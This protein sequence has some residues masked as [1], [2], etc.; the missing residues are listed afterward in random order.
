LQ[1]LK[2]FRETGGGALV[3]TQP[4]MAGRI[5]EWLL[6]ASQDS[7]IH[8]IASTGFHKVCYYFGDSYIFYR[9]EQEIAELYISEIEQGMLT[10]RKGGLK[11]TN[12]RAG[13]LKVVVE[14]GGIFCKKIYE[15]L[16][17]AVA[18]AQLKTG[19]PVMCHA[20]QGCDAEEVVRFYTDAGVPARSIW[21]AH[22]DRKIHDIE[23][24]KAVASSGVYLEYDTIFRPNY[25][26][27]TYECKL[28]RDMISAGYENKLLL[29]LDSNRERLE[30]Y[31]GKV[32]LSCLQEVFMPFLKSSGV[33]AGEIQKLMYD[34]PQEALAITKNKE[35]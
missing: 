14:P 29:G 32:G 8:I 1:E 5:A 13:L 9:T 24:H 35:R 25:H 12:V 11:R 21:I 15:K 22:L 7:G 19:V 34:N 3:D 2:R 33:T 30:S 23:R 17:A 31:G 6:K 16:H 4:V 26:T 20:E 27:T 10:S 18:A 28:I